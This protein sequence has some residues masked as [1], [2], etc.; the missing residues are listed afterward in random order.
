MAD[1]LE[2]VSYEDAEDVV[3]QGEHGD[4]FYIIV[5]GHAV[6]TQK[7]TEESEQVEVGLLGPSDYFGTHTHTHTHTHTC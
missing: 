2:P 6:V 4:E 7:K 5:E 1:A 3:V